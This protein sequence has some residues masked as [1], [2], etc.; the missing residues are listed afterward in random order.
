MVSSA[1][2]LYD[3]LCPVRAQV[4][5]VNLAAAQL[6]RVL[7]K[8]RISRAVGRLCEQ[9]LPSL[10]SGAVSRTYSQLY[11]VDIEEAAAPHGCYGSFDAFFTRSLREGI[12]PISDAKIV[13][14]CD[15][16]ISALGLI[17][18][19]A[20]LFIKGRPYDVG[21]LLGQP[22]LSREYMGGQ[23]LVIYLSPSDYHRVH[24]P[25]DGRLLSVLAIP[26]DCYPVN[27]LGERCVPQLF[28]RN[29]RVTFFIEADDNSQMALI[30]VGALIVG[31]IAVNAFGDYDLSTGQH[32]LGAGLRI[33]RGD[34]IGSFHL[35]S[36]VVLLV[37]PGVTI[38][39]LEGKVRYG[40]SLIRG[41]A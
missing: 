9:R 41:S 14:P 19:G 40:Q 32:D 23:Y 39:A 24:A 16:V 31:R 27:S 33:Q 6:L 13:S 2:Y 20:R 5:L 25:I 30:M 36:T 38:C 21:E 7:P 26:G 11:G 34:E 12:R 18:D 35:G 28:I 8:E 3:D 10:V 29:R 37:Q 15:G 4:S 22:E 1:Y 17:D